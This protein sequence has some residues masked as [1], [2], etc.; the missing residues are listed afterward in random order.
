MIY[1]QS[2]QYALRALTYLAGERDRLVTVQEISESEDIPR[3]FLA[4]LLHL[5][6]RAGIVMSVQGQGGG[7]TLARN[8]SEITLLDV[9]ECVDGRQDF[10][11][12]AFGLPR[13]GDE[14]P[15]PFHERWKAVRA[16]VERFLREQTLASVHGTLERKRAGLDDPVAGRD[17]AGG[18]V[19]G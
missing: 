14:M 9:V 11:K 1:S 15:C 13:C 6:R 16:E 10:D 12:C 8:P 17:S 4:K 3:Q 7:F 19:P 18:S 2:A 5:L